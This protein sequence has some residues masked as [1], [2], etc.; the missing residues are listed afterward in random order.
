VQ[1]AQLSRFVQHRKNGF[2]RLQ[3][4]ALRRI[5]QSFQSEHLPLP[6]F[7]SPALQAS[8]GSCRQLRARCIQGADPMTGI[9][10]SIPRQ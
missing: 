7:Q 3:R 2:E 6:G 4:V 1:R 8:D 10:V 9:A 5:G